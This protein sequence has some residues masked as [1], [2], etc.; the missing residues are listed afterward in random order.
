MGWG[1]WGEGLQERLSFGKAGTSRASSD[2]MAAA[3]RVRQATALRAST[4]EIR[5]F[6]SPQ[7]RMKGDHIGDARRR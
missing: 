3:G 7:K 5:G 1:A 2:R 6:P 4:A